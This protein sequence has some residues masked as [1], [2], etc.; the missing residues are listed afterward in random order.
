MQT[1]FWQSAT[2]Y[3][4]YSSRPSV[5]FD[6]TNSAT[7]RES[8]MDYSVTDKRVFRMST[9]WVSNWRKS[10]TN[11]SFLQRRAILLIIQHG[12]HKCKLSY[13]C[14]IAFDCDVCHRLDLLCKYVRYHNVPH[15]SPVRLPAQEFGRY[16]TFLVSLH[17]Y[18]M[19]MNR[20]TY[21][22]VSFRPVQLPLS[23]S[24]TLPLSHSPTLIM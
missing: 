16:R 1:K 8:K 3:R 6:Y 18:I 23:H 4:S 14:R 15:I 22:G 20:T 24:P 10:M 13:I 19:G 12:R 5:G 7:I 21:L 9:R 2:V 11:H 17:F